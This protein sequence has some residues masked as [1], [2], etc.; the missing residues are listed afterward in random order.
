M[1]GV[2][3]EGIRFV[4]VST[5]DLHSIGVRRLEIRWIERGGE[6]VGMGMVWRI[7]GNGNIDVFDIF[8][9]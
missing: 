1:V 7:D 2:T 4:C 8:A 9:A 3:F 5:R 6:R